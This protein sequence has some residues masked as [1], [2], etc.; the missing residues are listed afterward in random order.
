MFRFLL[1][2]CT[3]LPVVANADDVQLVSALQRTYSA[4]VGIDESLTDL[5]KMAGINT[6][7]TAVG[8]GLGAGAVVAGVK[9]AD[10]DARIKSLK[11]EPND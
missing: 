5:K 3:L 4:C 2:F 9:K 7:I 10:V 6:A 11:E 8:T 1:V